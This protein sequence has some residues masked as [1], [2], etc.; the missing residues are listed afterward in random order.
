MIQA[1]SS[2]LAPTVAQGATEQ[3][4]S[5]LQTPTQKK[6]TVKNNKLGV[7]AKILDGLISNSKQ[8]VAGATAQ[9]VTQAPPQSAATVLSVKTAQRATVARKTTAHTAGDVKAET[10]VKDK[11]SKT[12]AKAAK[13]AGEA[14]PEQKVSDTIAIAE[15]ASGAMVGVTMAKASDTIEKMSDTAVDIAIAEKAPSVFSDNANIVTVAG[16]NAN[17]K[18]S[19][20]VSKKE[21]GAFS[22]SAAETKNVVLQDTL[23]QEVAALEEALADHAQPARNAA[24]LASAANEVSHD[25]NVRYTSVK[26]NVSAEKLS[27]QNL[28]AGT[29]KA[30]EEPDNAA[31][32]AELRGKGRLELRDLRVRDAGSGITSAAFAGA[33]KTATVSEAGTQNIAEI[34]LDLLTDGTKP[35]DTPIDTSEARTTNFENLLARELSQHLNSDI[36]QQAQVL[37]RDGD[38]G[39][40]KLSLR[41]ES[42]GIVKVRFEMVENRI[43]GQI[44]VESNEALRA[45][46]REIQSLEQ[47]FRDSGFSGV[48]LYTALASDSDQNSEENWQQQENA[49][50]FSERFA[51]GQYE[52]EVHIVSGGRANELST[53]NMLA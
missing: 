48:S 25:K 39:T 47:A 51:A 26:Q 31:K 37:L 1:I 14:V 29:V 36:V 20:T 21:A 27:V 52:P 28:F 23:P 41:P 15:K 16:A 5:G 32:P 50:F 6:A 9:V 46:D 45:F 2:Q 33:E 18:V 19:D 4:V 24:D 3:T 22:S 12:P 40:I 34:S 8:G 53:V 42:L 44:I 11:A 17:V 30:E 43:T 49:A 7:F 38:A 13:K 35:F 10:V